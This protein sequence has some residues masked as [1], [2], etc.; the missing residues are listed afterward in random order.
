MSDVQAVR[1]S[2]AQNEVVDWAGWNSYIRRGVERKKILEVLQFSRRRRWWREPNG[3]VGEIPFS[4]HVTTLR[5]GIQSFERV[6]SWVPA[7]MWTVNLSHRPFPHW[8]A[9]NPCS[10]HLLPHR[11]LSVFLYLH[12]FFHS[13]AILSVYLFTVPLILLPNVSIW[14]PFPLAMRLTVRW[15]RIMWSFNI[16][17]FICSTDIIEDIPGPRYYSSY[18]GYNSEQKR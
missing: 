2:A 15:S 10:S 5:E 13:P 16:Y 12:N 14:P 8:P 11:L 7:G 9:S 1:L 6:L 4:S 17:S 18:G 3:G